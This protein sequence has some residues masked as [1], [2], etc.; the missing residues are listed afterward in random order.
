MN[1]EKA[2]VKVDNDM[3]SY[4]KKF[5]KGQQNLFSFINNGNQQLNGIILVYNQEASALE[6]FK[7]EKRKQYIKLDD[8]LTN[9]IQENLMDVVIY[10]RRVQYEKCTYY[11]K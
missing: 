8:H 1:V 11:K 7:L 6:D 3:V 2:D 9:I 5:M 10:G 4:R